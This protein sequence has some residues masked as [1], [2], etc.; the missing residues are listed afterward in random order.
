MK[1][2][3]NH[4]DKHPA[5]GGEAFK[6]VN[7]CLRDYYDGEMNKLNED[8]SSIAEKEQEEKEIQQMLKKM[9]V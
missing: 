1:I 9:K 3:K 8:D 7:G 5:D 2:S 4:P 6:A